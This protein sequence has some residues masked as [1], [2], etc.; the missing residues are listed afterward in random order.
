MDR[1]A[2]AA[3]SL[4]TDCV[5]AGISV[6]TRDGRV[7]TR[8]ATGELPRLCDRLQEET[9][10]G[11]CVDAA[12]GQR[13]V[14]SGDLTDEPRWPQWAPRATS[15]LGVGSVLCVQLFTDQ[16]QLGALNLFSFSRHA[17]GGSARDEAVAIAAHAAVALAAAE[18]I[19]QLEIGLARRTMIGQATGV[20][21]E[22]YGLGPVAAF[23]VLLRLS[24]EQSRKVYELATEVVASS[25]AG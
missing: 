13:L 11:P 12:W 10:Q 16:D 22:R 25:S 14:Y 19:D 5:A 18:N 21:M 8:G 15:E 24:S 1:I 23:D 20:V 2:Q 6:V 3:V 9:H 4:V 7:G 17:F